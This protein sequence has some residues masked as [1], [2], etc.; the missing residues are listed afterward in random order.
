MNLLNLIWLVPAYLW[1]AIVA[2]GTLYAFAWLIHRYPG[3][4][5]AYMAL[6]AMA[7]LL[8]RP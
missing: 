4:I 3:L 1:L 8:F 7:M 2:A 5:L 6:L